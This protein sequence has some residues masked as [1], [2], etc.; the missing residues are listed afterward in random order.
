MYCNT[1]EI[2]AHLYNYTPG[3]ITFDANT[4]RYIWHEMQLVP[5]P[6][7]ATVEAPAEL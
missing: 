5:Q 1:Q 4:M 2:A 7:E 3:S 6:F